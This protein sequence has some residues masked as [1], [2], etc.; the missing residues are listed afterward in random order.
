MK[1][2]NSNMA[3]R[4]LNR[5]LNVPYEVEDDLIGIYYFMGRAQEDQGNNAQALEFY[6]KA[7]RISE[8]FGYPS[9]QAGS[10][11]EIGAIHANRWD[12]DEALKFF[13]SALQICERIGDLPLQI[14]TLRGIG[15][16][17]AR[18]EK[19][20]EAMDALIKAHDICKTLGQKKALQRVEEAIEILSEIIGEN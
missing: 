7:L 15:I 8:H 20:R 2:G 3:V 11:G 17:Y 14:E 1:M 19:K 4:A 13:E 12:F 16:V 10:L 9:I 18:Q 6:E 5:A